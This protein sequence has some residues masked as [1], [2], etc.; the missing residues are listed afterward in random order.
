[1]DCYHVAVPE[2]C[3]FFERG[4]VYEDLTSPL[5]NVFNKDIV[6][7]FAQACVISNPVERKQRNVTL[8]VTPDAHS[9]LSQVK[10]LS[11]VQRLCVSRKRVKLDDF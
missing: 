6:T 5:R 7:I 8:R 4:I 10:N 11:N 1:M 9:I 3:L 2:K